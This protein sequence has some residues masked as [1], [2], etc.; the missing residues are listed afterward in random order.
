[1]TVCPGNNHFR[2][3][4]YAAGRTWPRMLDRTMQRTGDGNLQRSHSGSMNIQACIRSMDAF[5]HGLLL[6]AGQLNTPHTQAQQDGDTDQRCRGKH[7]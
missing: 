2:G 5:D 1:M 7:G 4:F 3:N 6:L